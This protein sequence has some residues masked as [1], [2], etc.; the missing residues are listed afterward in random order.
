[1]NLIFNAFASK[2]EQ[3]W[4]G[5]YDCV[6]CSLITAKETNPDDEVAL[7]TNVSPP[8]QLKN[9]L[10]EKAIKIIFHE[11]DSFVTGEDDSWQLA[12]YKLSAMEFAVKELSYD[13][14]LMVDTDTIFQY[15][16]AALWKECEQEVLLYP[17]SHGYEHQQVCSMNKTAKA[18]FHRPMNIIHYGGEFMAGSKLQVSEF[19]DRCKEL[20]SRMISSGVSSPQG[21]EFITSI[22]AT[23]YREHIKPTTAYIHREWTGRYYDCS[24]AYYYEKLPIIHIPSG[25]NAQFT[26]LSRYYRKHKRFPKKMRK[27]YCLPSI[28]PPLRYFLYK[29]VASYIK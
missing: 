10:E 20:Y 2:K 11:F 4:N 6:L 25:K 14:F 12:Y 15:S 8:Q 3:E 22:V 27:Y 24:T 7:I 1:M 5:Y 13:N 9:L 23:E 17:L 21:D 18:L 19:I 29:F 28:N 26:V 16:V